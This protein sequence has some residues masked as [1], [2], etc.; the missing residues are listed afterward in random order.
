MGLW[1]GVLQL[2]LGNAA[3]HQPHGPALVVVLPLPLATAYKAPR[4][5]GKAG[6]VLWLE[7]ER[8]LGYQEFWAGVKQ[9]GY[10]HAACTDVLVLQGYLLEAALLSFRLLV[11]LN[12]V[13][14]SIM[15]RISLKLP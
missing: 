12:P 7:Q 8:G 3:G 11:H 1:A 5:Q 14:A 6:A 2:G 9:R 15:P 4:R 13:S 10:G